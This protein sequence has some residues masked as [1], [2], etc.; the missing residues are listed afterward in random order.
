LLRKPERLRGWDLRFL[1]RAL[2]LSQAQLGKLIDRDA[3]TIARWEKSKRR[4][5]PFADLAIRSRFAERFEGNMSLKTL[6]SFVDG[7]APK[8]PKTILLKF[9]GQ[10]WIFSFEPR[11]DFSHTTASARAV[12]DLPRGPGAIQVV[13]SVKGNVVRIRKQDYENVRQRRRGTSLWNLR[14]LPGMGMASPLSAT[15]LIEYTSNKTD[16]NNNT[17]H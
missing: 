14:S 1:R 3:Q 11:F 13:Y 7:T 4:I 8:L 16:S 17:V 15:P 10:D 6:L 9:E 5:A 12:V 2:E